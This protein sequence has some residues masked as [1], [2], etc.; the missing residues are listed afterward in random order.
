MVLVPD[1]TVSTQDLPPSV[2]AL[3]DTGTKFLF[4]LAERGKTSGLIG[5]DDALH[6]YQEWLDAYGPVA[7]YNANEA[8]CVRRHFDEDGAVLYFSRKAGPAAAAATGTAT[9]FTIKAKGPGASYST[10]KIGVASGVATVKD[11]TTVKEVSTTLSTV[12][13][14]QSWCAAF[15]DLV[16]ITPTTTGALADQADVTLSGG[17]PTDDRTNITDTQSQAAIDRFGKNLGPGQLC[18]AGDGRAQIHAIQAAHAL[19]NNRIAICDP[20]DTATAATIAALGTAIR[21]LGK[22]LARHCALLGDWLIVSGDAPGTQALVPPSAIYSGLCARIDA[23]GNP[24]QSV[25]GPAAF[26]RTAKAV[27]YTRSDADLQTFANAG[28]IPFI[29]DAG[30]IMPY[31]DIT[32]VD[33]TAY[34]QWWEVSTNRFWMRVT[35]DIKALG[36]AFMWQ[37]NTG[38]VDY[39]ALQ[40]AATVELSRWRGLALYEDGTNI[41]Y[42]VDTGPTVNTTAT[43]NAKKIRFA[44]GMVVAPC[45]RNA[46]AIMTNVLIGEAL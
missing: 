28:V 27:H 31:D 41:P 16:D 9:Q 33:S 7:A 37:A 4:G 21:A 38:S 24:N 14:L 39:A 13:D 12:A 23:T 6:S 42:S 36:K 35:A 32:P 25:A 46:E 19:A 15:S 44:I 34:P 17:S 30:V 29:A 22:D 11:G 8:Q 40:G 20:P 43:I 10:I 1:S 18:S 5:P 26:S 3:N 45:V 2:A